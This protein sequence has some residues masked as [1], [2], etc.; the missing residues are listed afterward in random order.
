MNSD[1]NLRHD[2]CLNAITLVIGAVV[3]NNMNPTKEELEFLEKR[4]KAIESA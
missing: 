4:R 3:D 2:S 1:Q